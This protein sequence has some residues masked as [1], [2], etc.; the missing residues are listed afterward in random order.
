MESEKVPLCQQQVDAL[1]AVFGDHQHQ[2]KED[3]N[4]KRARLKVLAA[5]KKTI[6]RPKMLCERHGAERHHGQNQKTASDP[7]ESSRGTCIY[8]EAHLPRVGT[9]IQLFLAQLE[10][11]HSARSWSQDALAAKP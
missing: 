2:R 11:P 9:V 8:A 10:T 3:K 6:P 4:H 1:F 5:V 7:Q